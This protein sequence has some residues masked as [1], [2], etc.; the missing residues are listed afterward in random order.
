MTPKEY[1]QKARGLIEKKG[2]LTPTQIYEELGQPPEGY[3]LKA[4]GSGSVS[5][6]S[7]EKRAG[8]RSKA[9]EKRSKFDV[10]STPIAGYEAKKLKQQSSE[11][12]AQAEMFGLEPTQIEH[13]AD[14][15]DAE[16]LTAGAPGDPTNLLQVQQSEAR[17]KDQIK[18]VVGRENAVTLNPAEESLRVIP[19]K[20]FDPI[21]DPSTLPGIDIPID[22]PVK[23]VQKT[24]S[25]IEFK[26]GKIVLKALPF[27]GAA[28][29]IISAGEVPVVG[30]VVQA[31]PV[32]G[33]NTSLKTED[34]QTGGDAYLSGS[35][36]LS[37]IA[38]QGCLS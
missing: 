20:F 19:K 38:V 9:T 35:I 12:R 21:A 32:A 33:G 7:R 22:T 36:L 14:Q 31:E 8:R 25:Q 13:L 11:V 2:R 15:V 6:E 34:M 23:E 30:D 24:L 26:G 4:D 5:I 18:L 17:Y 16:G 10:T 27:V 1:L 37:V 28:A 29:G 3:R